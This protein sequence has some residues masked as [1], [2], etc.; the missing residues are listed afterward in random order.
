MNGGFCFGVFREH[1]I[2]KVPFFN[3]GNVYLYFK[4][5]HVSTKLSPKL[6][7]EIVSSRGES[8][9]HYSEFLRDGAV[10]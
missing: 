2:Q 7:L 6:S 8:F 3:C 9:S 1:K 10:R 5:P 4:K